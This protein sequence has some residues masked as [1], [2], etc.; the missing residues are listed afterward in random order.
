MSIQE[1]QSHQSNTVRTNDTEQV[2][3]HIMIQTK[4]EIT[5][6]VKKTFVYDFTPY[7]KESSIYGNNYFA[8]YFEW[9]GASREAWFYHC[10]S[11]DFLLP[12][13]LF[14]TKEAQNTYQHE[15]FPFQK[16][17]CLVNVKDLRFTSFYIVFKF[18][19]THDPNQIYSEG[20]QRIVF[21]DKNKHP[22][23]IPI[24]I[25]DKIKLYLI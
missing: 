12:L 25:F 3:N 14:L 1:F 22:Q 6:T 17:R 15:T 10:I 23:K 18:C 16:I 2:D 4:K 7:L 5:T 9:Q 19:D 8:R 21:V 11:S 24:D 20:Y 13:G